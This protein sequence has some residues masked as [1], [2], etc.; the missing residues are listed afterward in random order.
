MARDTSYDERRRQ[1]DLED[2]QDQQLKDQRKLGNP[3]S[4]G[5]PNKSGSRTGEAETDKL[6]EGFERAEP[7]IEQLNSLYNQ[8][9]TGVEQKPPLER[10]KQLDQLMTMMQGLGKPTSAYQFRFNSLNASYV[11]HRERWD[12]MLKDLE[13]GKIKRITGPKRAG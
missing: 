1:R 11:A 12:R 9:I 8:Y 7:L 10:R 2:E 6:L 4:A 13:S 3:I 5:R